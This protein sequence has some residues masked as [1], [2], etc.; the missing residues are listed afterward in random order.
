MGQTTNEFSKL[1]QLDYEGYF[2]LRT[3]LQ[4]SNANNANYVCIKNKLGLVHKLFF[5]NGFCFLSLSFAYY[6]V[7]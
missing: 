4:N 7:L 5:K 3:F 1:A 2:T 6:L